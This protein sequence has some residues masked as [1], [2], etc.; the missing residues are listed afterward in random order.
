MSRIGLLSPAVA[1]V[2]P[3]LC[4]RLNGRANPRVCKGERWGLKGLETEH[5][6]SIH[7]RSVKYRRARQKENLSVLRLGRSGAKDVSGG[8]VSPV[9]KF[10]LSPALSLGEREPRWPQE[11]KCRM[12][13]ENSR[14]NGS[15]SPFCILPYSFCIHP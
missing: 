4:D 12:Q 3:A 5:E 8:S 7:P 6:L 13:N 15:H 11:W 9:A 1:G 10:P 2:G 14:L